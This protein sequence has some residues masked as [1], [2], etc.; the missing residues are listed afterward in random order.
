MVIPRTIP[1]LLR[2]VSGLNRQKLILALA[3]LLGLLIARPISAQSAADYKEPDYSKFKVEDGQ[4]TLEVWSWVVG[5]DQ[6]VKDFEQAFPNIKVHVNNVGGGPAE[7]QK[8]QT[9]LK[10]GSG[11]PDVV[12]I[13][14]DFLPS[15]VATDGLA[16]ISQYGANDAKLYFVDWTWGQVSPDGKAVYGIPQDTGPMAFVYNKKI[17]DQYQLTVPTTWEEFAR[18]A[19]KLAKASD[20][21]V[22]IANFKPTHA[23]WFIGLA[24]ASGGEFFKVKGDTWIQSLNNSAS[25]KVLTFWDGLIKNGYVSTLPDFTAEFYSALGSD[26]IASSP[27]AA[28]GPGVF[29]AS[30]KEKTSGEWRLAP[31]PQWSKD[32]P[33][34]SGNWGGSCNAVTKQSKYPKAATL[35]SI[36]LNT[37]KAPVISNWISTGIFPASISGLAS[38]ELND[39]TKNPSKFCGGQ[40]IAQVYSDAAKAINVEFAWAPWFAFANDNYNKHIADLLSGAATVKQALDGWQNDCLKNGKDAGYDVKSEGGTR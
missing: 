34:H 21:K 14:Y 37:H 31:L 9:V 28:W 33:F 24:W 32:Q 17:F 6:T 38:P 20:G 25:E 29:A 4:I 26:Q 13:E 5:L 1:L 40:N 22:K 18:E 16:D 19:E 11:A 7:Y 15:F 36:W 39:P 23:P 35:F 3:I 2:P 8:L 12:Q 27:E 30:L 10:A